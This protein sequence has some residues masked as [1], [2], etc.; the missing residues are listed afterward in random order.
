MATNSE[1]KALKIKT[2]VAEIVKLFT[3][4]DAAEQL[5]FIERCPP[6]PMIE[7]VRPFISS[8]YLE[9]QLL[10]LCM[11]ADPYC[12]G[13][14]PPLGVAIAQ[15]AY[16][17]SQTAYG[18]KSLRGYL[19]TGAQAAVTCL[20]GYGSMGRHDDA[21]RVGRA[22][23]DW[24][25]REGHDALKPTLLM[26]CIE[27]HLNL[28]QFE[29]AGQLLAAAEQLSIPADRPADIQRLKDLRRR[30]DSV[31]R[32]DATQLPP[33][34]TG[35]E[36]AFRTARKELADHIAR[37]RSIIPAELAGQFSGV[38]DAL[39]AHVETNVNES[40][41]EWL[42]RSEAIR[43]QLTEFLSGDS[44][45]MTQLRNRHR[46]TQ[47][48][49]LFADPIKGHD[50]AAIAESVATLFEARAWAKANDCHDD[51]N[52]ALWGL[53]LGYSRT[54]REE[55]AI[56]ALQALRANLEAR[57]SQ[58]ADPMQRA[59]ALNKYPYLFG[60]LCRLLYRAGRAADLL[61]AMEG[62]KGRVLADV[63][64]KKRGEVV[65][66]ATFAQ[67][68]GEL[69]HVLHAAGAHYLSY[70]VD[71][72]VTYAVL[73]TRDGSMHCASMPI[74]KEAL[75]ALVPAVDPRMWNRARGGL[76][77]RPAP[78]HLAD[79]LAC[80]VDWLAPFVDAGTL[81]L[82]DHLCYCPD[83]ELHLVPLHYVRLLGKPLFHHVSVS[84][85]HSAAAMIALLAQPAERPTQ[86]AAISVP[87]QQD[88][89]DPLKL[90]DLARVSEWLAEHA[91]G[92]TLARERAS[93]EALAA[94][95][96]SDR[97][98]HFATHGWFPPNDRGGRNPNP[99]HASGLPLAR[100][101]ALPLLDRV[102][103]GRADEALL[104]PKRVLDLDFRASHR[105]PRT[106]R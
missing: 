91:S 106:P 85:I 103:A 86:F 12:R 39:T 93:V 72:E 44:G 29:N 7:A 90:S 97:V 28:E 35:G 15:A 21:V 69:A 2:A 20:I 100:D 14:D 102:S 63:L 48:C 65:P 27:A 42:A 23:S 71:D 18:E 43:S 77:G 82:G 67:A 58:I 88:L 55:Q 87:A 101:G 16:Q 52:D 37:M 26:S 49:T 4:G 19:D 24:L 68:P 79:R 73:V 11:F 57:R 8:G 41:S 6:N 59:G 30:F 89:G 96:L 9:P 74:G 53:Y 99:F 83:E 70:F 47:A 95:D 38:A 81:G 64:T 80:L 51:E 22:A 92:T 34:H 46:T 1:E 5:A 66:D 76:F 45:G 84:R 54:N 94:L 40:Q 13:V 36:D 50:P 78:T 32:Q 56:G 3:D 10:A 105:S 33:A 31:A 104:T 75:R 25:D 61:D 62:A 60:A 17:L 98:V